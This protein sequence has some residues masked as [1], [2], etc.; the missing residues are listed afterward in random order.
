MAA[1]L[2][3]GARATRSAWRALHITTQDTPN[4][5]GL[6]FRPDEP[7]L[8]DATSRALKGTSL[9]FRAAPPA[10]VSPLAAALF[11]VSGVE[12]VFIKEGFLTITKA[13]G[14]GDEGGGGAS[15]DGPGGVRNEVL[16]RLMDFFATGS[17]AVHTSPAAMEYFGHTDG[18]AGKLSVDAVT[19]LSSPS[20]PSSPSSVEALAAAEAAADGY[21]VFT[22]KDIIARQIRPGVEEDGGDI[23]FHDYNPDTGLVRLKLAGSCVGCPSSSVTLKQGVERVL[24]HH[25]PDEVTGVEEFTADEQAAEAA[26]EAAAATAVAAAAAAGGAEERATSAAAT[27]AAAAAVAAQ[28]TVSAAEM[29]AQV[30]SHPSHL[31]T[32]HTPCLAC[33]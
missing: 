8:D 31:P 21:V 15:W 23:L 33:A 13:G 26:T 18:G 32:L 12:G 6:L 10:A 28:E 25:F 22:I 27:A 14:A 1:I 7:L 30:R 16:M 2:L 29:E 24:Q 20:S 9:D 3:R 5:D 11:G 4:P 17:P 19:S